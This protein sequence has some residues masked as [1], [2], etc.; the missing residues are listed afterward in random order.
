M[1]SCLFSATI[2]LGTPGT[3]SGVD[4]DTTGY[5]Q[6]APMTIEIGGHLRDSPGKVYIKI[7]FRKDLIFFILTNP[8]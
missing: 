2:Q 5:R 6:C 8:S 3:V 4:V 1:Y 7:S